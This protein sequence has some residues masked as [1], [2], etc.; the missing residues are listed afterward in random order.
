MEALV[1]HH[2]VRAVSAA[3]LIVRDPLLAEDIVQEAFLRA[4]EKIDQ[5]DESRPFGPWF[6]RSVINVSIKAARKQ[7]RFI[8]LDEASDEEVK[9]VANWLIDPDPHPKKF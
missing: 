4:A 9:N 5:F 3:Y 7:K 6:L 1:K 8:R 2:Q